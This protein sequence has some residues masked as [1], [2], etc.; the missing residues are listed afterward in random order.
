MISYLVQCCCYSNR[1][2]LPQAMCTMPMMKE[3]HAIVYSGFLR[4]RLWPG[5]LCQLHENLIAV[6]QPSPL[7]C[8]CHHTKLLTSLP[9]TY[10]YQNTV[11]IATATQLSPLVAPPPGADSAH[12]LTGNHLHPV[13]RTEQVSQSCLH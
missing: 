6:F 11:A 9:S 12:C 10:I 7:E 1:P 2:T 8:I 5:F 13:S 4:P 3:W